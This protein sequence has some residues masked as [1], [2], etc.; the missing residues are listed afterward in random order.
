MGHKNYIRRTTNGEVPNV[1]LRGGSF[2]KDR[3]DDL[4]T[5]LERATSELNMLMQD[6]LQAQEGKV[7]SLHEDVKQVKALMTSGLMDCQ[8]GKVAGSRSDEKAYSQSMPMTVNVS[9]S[10]VEQHANDSQHSIVDP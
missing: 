8:S 5:H 6:S 2:E 1:L 4:Y 3:I 9:Q 7:D 10:G